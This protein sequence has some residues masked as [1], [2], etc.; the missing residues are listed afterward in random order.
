MEETGLRRLEVEGLRGCLA[1]QG[2]VGEKENLVG[3]TSYTCLHC[4]PS[5]GHFCVSQPQSMGSVP[6]GAPWLFAYEEQ[7]SRGGGYVVLLS[8]LLLGFQSLLSAL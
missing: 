8:E 3:L 6:L 4:L 2:L 1:R 5:P 7:W